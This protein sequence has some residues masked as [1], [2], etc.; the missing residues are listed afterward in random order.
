MHNDYKNNMAD[1]KDYKNKMKEQVS[2]HYWSS[3]QQNHCEQK[4][5][6]LFGRAG[7]A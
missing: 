5:D 3:H 1:N 6:M 2:K 4:C 7:N